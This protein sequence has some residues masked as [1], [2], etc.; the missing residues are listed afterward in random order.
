MPRG[1]I[2]QLFENLNHPADAQLLL[3]ISNRS[4]NADLLKEAI[5]ATTNLER[6]GVLLCLDENAFNPASIALQ[7]ESCLFPRDEFAAVQIADVLRDLLGIDEVH[8]LV[9]KL[10][11]LLAGGNHRPHGLI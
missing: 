4:R 2:A 3:R 8:R 11:A 5:D 1:W 10:D 7:G 6:D 9:E